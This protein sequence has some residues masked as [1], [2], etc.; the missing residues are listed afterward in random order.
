MIF[1]RASNTLPAHHLTC[2][3]AHLNEMENGRRNTYFH[4]IHYTRPCKNLMSGRIM[5]FDAPRAHYLVL[6]LPALQHILMTV[7]GDEWCWGGCF[8]YSG[9]VFVRGGWDVSHYLCH[10]SSVA[11][12]VTHTWQFIPVCSPVTCAS[13]PVSYLC[14]YSS[15]LC[16]NSYFYVIWE[17]VFFCVCECVR[18]FSLSLFLPSVFS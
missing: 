3:S 1:R 4:D 6:V 17:C 10:L 18:W 8:C 7:L 13:S 9:E 2:P 14:L 11:S 5:I 12:P 15:C 16:Y